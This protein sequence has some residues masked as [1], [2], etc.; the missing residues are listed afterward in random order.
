MSS[1]ETLQKRGTKEEKR[2][3]LLEIE[4]CV[5]DEV[6]SGQEVLH[7]LANVR[8]DLEQSLLECGG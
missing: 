4:T 5:G 2:S 8:G 7:L 6:S 3:C 1:R